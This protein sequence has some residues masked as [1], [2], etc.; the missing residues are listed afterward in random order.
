MSLTEQEASRV[1]GVTQG[2]RLLPIF[3]SSDSLCTRA[4][5]GKD[6]T[7]ATH[8][9]DDPRTHPLELRFL[10]L[11]STFPIFG[12]KPSWR[13]TSGHRGWGGQGELGPAT[14]AGQGQQTAPFSRPPGPRHTS[15]PATLSAHSAEAQVKRPPCLML[16]EQYLWD[17]MYTL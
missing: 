10:G 7:V 13:T 3:P 5:K 11:P 2:Q 9:G 14:R 4:L 6:T 8:L 15:S 12:P 1:R 16:P 17:K